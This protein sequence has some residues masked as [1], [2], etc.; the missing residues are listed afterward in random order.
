[1]I[2]RVL[3]AL[4]LLIPSLAS[5][6]DAAGPSLTEITEA[7]LASPHADRTSEAFTHWNEE[8]GGVPGACAVCHSSIGLL[9][10]LGSPMQTVGAIANAVPTGSVIGCAS[11]HSAASA[12]LT[13]V[14]FP[15]GVHLDVAAGSATCSV[16]HQGRASTGAVEAAIGGLAADDVSPD[17]GFVNSHYAM[18]AATQAGSAAH[19]GY[20]YPDRAYA[21]PFT[22]FPDLNT[23]SSCH[24]PH[25][26]QVELSSC[27]GCHEG[28]ESFTDIRTSPA[29]F[30]GDGDVTEG[31]AD[32]IATLHARLDEAIALYAA[33][34]IGMPVIYAPGVYPYFFN[35]TNGDG[36]LSEG[37]A[38]FPN[39]YQSWSPRLLRAAYNYQYVRQDGGAF[40]HNPHYALHLLYD[41][42]ADLGAAV[43]VDIT[44]YTRP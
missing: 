6:Q 9:E 40:A 15:S 26:L 33:E 10:Y 12:A 1:M 8:E 38:A 11:C 19:G 20:E 35:D 42:L 37:E 16:C 3:A 17:L 18:A 44:A 5:A 30:D 31:I 41:S 27:I 24:A 32:P 34:V 39:R 43:E 4:V 36:A 13:S 23:C 7:W 21:G 25:G 22:H 28:A 2:I 14:P 29:D